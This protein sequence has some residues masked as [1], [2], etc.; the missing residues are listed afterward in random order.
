MARHKYLE[1]KGE[2]ESLRDKIWNIKRKMMGLEL[3]Q[4]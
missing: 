2:G 1:I 3:V 4:K